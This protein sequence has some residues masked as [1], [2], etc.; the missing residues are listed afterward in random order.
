MADACDRLRALPNELYNQ[1]LAHLGLLSIKN[2]RLASPVHAAKCLSPAF[3]AYYE[4]QETDLT[5]PSLQRLREI[6]IHP[7]LAPAVK[8]LV[9]VAVFHDPSSLLTRIRRLRDPLRGPWAT[10]GNSDRN[11]ELLD[12]IGQLYRI[13]SSRHEQQGQFS[14]DIVGSLS[15]ILENLGS[16]DVLRLT[17]RVLRPDLDNPYSTSS[18]RFV[19]WNCLWADC[20]RVLKL[21]TS[22]MSTSKVDVATFSVFNDCFGKVQSRHFLDLN[23]DLT[24]LDFLTHTG[25]SIRC[26]NLGLSTVTVVPTTNDIVFSSDGSMKHLRAVRIPTSETRA[27]ADENFPGVA[28]F[29]RQTPNLEALDLFLYNTLEGAPWAYSK[30][31]SHISKTV[32]LPKLRRLT[33]RGIWT[34]PNSLLLFLRTHP[35]LT[36][37]DL[38]EVHVSGGTWDPILKHFQSM[39]NLAELHL[40]NLWSGSEHLLN[41]QPRNPVYDDEERVLGCYFPTR[42]GTMVHTRDISV[43]EIKNGL[44]FVKS[45]GSS[46]G[47]GSR[48]LMKWIQQRKIDYGPPEEPYVNSR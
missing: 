24:N 30:L 2:L 27:R 17:T 38:R 10:L 29:L 13:M 42:N 32:H 7:A 9:V 16:V 22:A 12:K 44:E 35:D 5:P 8:R 11:M 46:R 1:V 4:Q 3:L 41:L 26:L 40:E 31:F 21:V 6:T 19:N 43:E 15:C 39:L 47:K 33:L 25:A 23:T 36:H 48:H 14:D 37:I 18:S 45:R 34:T 20:H 28:L